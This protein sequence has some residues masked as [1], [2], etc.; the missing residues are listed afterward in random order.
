[1]PVKLKLLKFFKKMNP[2]GLCF[3]QYA[4]DKRTISLALIGKRE[5]VSPKMYSLYN[6]ILT[7]TPPSL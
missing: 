6:Q 4:D 1:M 7:I 2:L 3:Q 5:F